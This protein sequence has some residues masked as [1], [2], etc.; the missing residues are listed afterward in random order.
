VKAR[1]MASL[2]FCLVALAAASDPAGGQTV[3]AALAISPAN[4]DFGEHAVG[5]ENQPMTVTVSN[6]TNAAIKLQNVFVSGIDFS[7]KTDCG[8]GLAPGA[9]CT[10]QIFFKPAISGQRV[11]SLVI[12]GSD[13]GS[14]HFVALVGT[15]K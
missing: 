1:L 9:S 15:G 13:S 3:P 14:P 11:G 7:N 6:P 4:L 12:T 2:G 5:S 10:V 8:Q